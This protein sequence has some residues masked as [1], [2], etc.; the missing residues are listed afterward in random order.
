MPF[1]VSNKSLHT[2]GIGSK[3][4][5]L[6]DGNETA[7]PS[8]DETLHKVFSNQESIVITSQSFESLLPGKEID[9]SVCDLC[10]TW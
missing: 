5:N 1:V 10:L 3:E 8:M 6:L 2:T 4:F 7:L 9:K